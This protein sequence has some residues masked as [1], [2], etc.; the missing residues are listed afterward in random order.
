MLSVQSSYAETLVRFNIFANQNRALKTSQASEF[1]DHP[2]NFHVTMC[3]F[4]RP[5]VGWDSTS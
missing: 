1:E 5:F 2:G 3:S 4:S